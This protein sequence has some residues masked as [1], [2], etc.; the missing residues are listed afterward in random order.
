MKWSSIHSYSN[1]KSYLLQPE[2]LLVCSGNIQLSSAR[3]GGYL[4]SA[5][6]HCSTVNRIWHISVYSSCLP[7]TCSSSAQMKGFQIAWRQVSLQDR[8][9]GSKWNSG[10]GTISGHAAQ[11]KKGQWEATIELAGYMHTLLAA[12]LPMVRRSAGADNSWGRLY[13]TVE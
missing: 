7:H 8:T 4:F 9:T 1:L 2:V 3:T 5:T 12:T 13:L 6:R 10:M 11:L